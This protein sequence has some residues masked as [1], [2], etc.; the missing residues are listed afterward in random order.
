MPKTGKN[1]NFRKNNIGV[2]SNIGIQK[3]ENSNT[4]KYNKK[5]YMIGSEYFTNDSVK[6]KYSA[7]IV[8]EDYGTVN[9]YVK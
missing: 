8:K 5:N 1:S 2:S 4:N 9:Y 7:Q 3:M 6:P